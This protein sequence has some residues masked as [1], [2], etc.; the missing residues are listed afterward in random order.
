MSMTS[1]VP[2]N[3]IPIVGYPLNGFPYA[4]VEPWTYSDGHTLIESLEDLKLYLKRVL[5]PITND[6]FNKLADAWNTEVT[7]LIT[8]V[9]KALEDQ[10][11]A[12][13]TALETQEANVNTALENQ[14]AANE[15]RIT[16]T[17]NSVANSVNSLTTFVNNK[18][19]GFETEFNETVEMFLQNSLEANDP[20]VAL[21]FANADTDS[22][23]TADKVYNIRGE[24]SR[25]V[26]DYS[27]KGDGVADDTAAIQAVIN[28]A[29]SEYKTSA[30]GVRGIVEIPAG[31]Y[32]I[33]DTIIQP[34]YIKV[35]SVGTVII[36]SYVVGKPAWWIAPLEN[37]PASL[38]PPLGKE[39]WHRGILLGGGDGGIVFVNRNGSYG[40]DIG[41]E[42][43]T[44][45]NVARQLNRYA[46]QDVA[47][48]GYNV[49]M[50][51]NTFNNYLGFFER[52]HIETNEIGVKIS[53]GNVNQNSGE[54]FKFSDSVIAGGLT[55]VQWNASAIDITFEGCSFDFLGTAF[56]F[57]AT[58]GWCNIN[59]IGGHLEV[60]NEGAR[61]T[62]EGG[63]V[64][65]DVLAGIW[66]TVTFIGVPY[67][68]NQPQMLFKGRVRLNLGIIFR[69][70]IFTDMTAANAV[71]VSD[72]SQVISDDVYFTSRHLIV[73]RTQNL[74]KDPSFSG[75][76]AGAAGSTAL[77][78]TVATSGPVVATISAETPFAGGKSLQAVITGNG[79]VTIR[80]KSKV[81]VIPGKTLHINAFHNWS[82]APNATASATVFWYDSEGVLISQAAQQQFVRFV[83]GY[84][85]WQTFDTYRPFVV[86]NGAVWASVQ[87]LIGSGS[88]DGV[89]T[90][91]ISELTAK[92][93]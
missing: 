68:C 80:S 74:L 55:G 24:L 43:G 62:A 38:Y 75:D 88:G 71:M 20:M 35:V 17:L 2:I 8:T 84:N 12:I 81:P 6:S 69:C 70:Q 47:I 21:M 64:R 10:A 58:G 77:N 76:T 16:E 9:D 57:T 52:M 1:I 67:V 65:S 63:V 27:V 51:V 31:K 23:K 7:K 54:N 79:N 89:A 66:P 25:N 29:A 83:P 82:A 56:H 50:L 37:D 73:N 11:A 53:G 28:A 78:W 49:G 46:I 91:R 34:S 72:L 42:L 59:I 40:T 39:Q 87:F 5:I 86:P 61:N 60:I 18:V 14:T 22:R 13:N 85:Q 92:L 90:Y 41:L 15:Q 33:T 19:N 3:P 48:Q 36:E 30:L 32:K 4:N 44:R 93:V 45:T 26:K